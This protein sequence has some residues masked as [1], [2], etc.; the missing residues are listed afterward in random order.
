MSIISAN[1]PDELK[2]LRQWLLWRYETRDG[3]RAKVPHTCQSYRA[4][5]TNPEHWS[6]FDYA[7]K[8]AARPGFAGVAFCFCCGGGYTGIDLDHVWQSDADEG[9]AWAEGI[10]ERFSD[11]YSEVSPSGQGVKIWVRARAP[12]CGRWPIEHGAIEVYDHGRFFTVT[13]GSNGVRVIADHQADV[14]LLIN[15]L[16]DGR[17][18]T[19]GRVISHEP[20]RNEAV[21]RSAQESNGKSHPTRPTT[22][23]QSR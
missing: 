8:A 17:Q 11:T 3:K 1:I 15:N 19:Q 22:A 4:S 6:R 20:R 16:D 21:P 14:E 2:P 7:V 12:R 23:R 18:Q 13:G 9:A 5:T 10:L